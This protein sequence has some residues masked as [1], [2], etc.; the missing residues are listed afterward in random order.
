M[1]KRL[2]RGALAAGVMGLAPVAVSHAAVNISNSCSSGSLVVCI[3]YTLTPIAATPQTDDYS[4]TYTV[5]S[6]NAGGSFFL[7]AVGLA[8]VTGTF[9]GLTSPAG[10]TFSNGAS[11]NCSDLSNI[12]GL[13]FCDATNGNSGITSVTFTFTYSGTEALLSTADVASH[14]QGIANGNGTCSAKPFTDVQSATTGVTSISA[15]DCTPTTS[16][17]EPASLLLVGS[18]L[19]GLGGLISR[20]RRA[21]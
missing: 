13:V 18:G 20:R 8:N 11:G 3:S 16:T 19:A 5:N 1:L 12:G 2:V 7:T 9:V 17:P 21:A 14:V 6:V 4:I 10:W 15:T